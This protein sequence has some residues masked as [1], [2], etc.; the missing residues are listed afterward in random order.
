MRETLVFLRALVATNLKASLA[1]RGAFWMQVVFMLLNNMIF[2]VMW[3]IFFDRFTEI[4]GWRIEDMAAIYGVGAG[5][6]GIAVVFGEGAR[7]LAPM[8]VGGDLD[9]FLA[10]PKP[11]LLQCVA[12]R[13]MAAGWGDMATGVVLF[14]VSGYTTPL[15]LAMLPVACLCAAT[16]FVATTVLVHSLAF[17]VGRIE[18]LAR[19]VSDFLVMFSVYP[20]TVFSGLL[21]ILLFTIIP[22]GFITYIP[23]DLVRD[24]RWTTL[25]VAV[26]G[27]MGYAALAA[28]V[29]RAGLRRYESGNRFGMRV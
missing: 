22:A 20:K 12:S 4:R 25:L 10:Q 1:L 17:W 24:F 3:W 26:A 13:S 5:G 8:I 23:V 7:H 19:Q 27:A 6:F 28:L 14:L 29:F 11:P 9:T 21:K 18:T 16:V 15:G 2:F